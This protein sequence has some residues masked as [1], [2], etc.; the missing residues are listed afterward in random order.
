MG[1]AGTPQVSLPVLLEASA[2][3]ASPPGSPPSQAPYEPEVQTGA[4]RCVYRWTCSFQ[5]EAPRGL[6]QGPSWGHDSSDWS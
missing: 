6:A 4:L 5:G 1:P 2:V 3:A